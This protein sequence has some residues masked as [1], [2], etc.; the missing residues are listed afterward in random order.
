MRGRLDKIRKGHEGRGRLIGVVLEKD[1]HELGSEEEDV[2][3]DSSDSRDSEDPKMRNFIEIDKRVGELEKLVGSSNAALDEVTFAFV[4]N[5]LSL[6]NG[7]SSDLPTSSTSVA[8][9]YAPQLSAGSAYTAP[10]SG[11]NFSPS[12]ATPLR[13]RSSIR[14]SATPTSNSATY[15]AS[16]P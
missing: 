1:R 12:Q 7:C 15:R 6:T 3:D 4:P 13:P 5:K 14:G 11:L 2:S 10:S 16:Y 8:S 9:H